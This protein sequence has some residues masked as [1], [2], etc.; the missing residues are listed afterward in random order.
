MVGTTLVSG[1]F[2]WFY[3]HKGSRAIATWFIFV[4]ALFLLLRELFNF[5]V[6]A[7]LSFLR[8]DWE[9]LRI[10]GGR[11]EAWTEVM[12]LIA[13]RPWFGYGF[14]SESALFHEF[15]IAFDLHAGS[16]AH[17][18]Y[19]GLVSQVGVLG[20]VIFFIPLL[21]FILVRSCRISL[22]SPKHEHYGLQLALNAVLLGGIAQ[23]FFESWIY[24]AGNAFSF[25]FWALLMISY[26]LDRMSATPPKN[27]KFVATP[28]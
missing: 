22:M 15:D 27:L 18:S 13:L 17:N 12:K 20:A 14:G 19:L 7:M 2:L 16:H 9:T 11:I 28:P 1:Y 3:F 4:A 6:N 8:M 10:G 26:Q 5:D 25:I 24:S 23:C 21:V